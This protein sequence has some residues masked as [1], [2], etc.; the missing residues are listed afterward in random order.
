MHACQPSGPVASLFSFRKP[1]LRASG[2]AQLGSPGAGQSSRPPQLSPSFQDLFSY[3]PSLMLE[4]SLWIKVY[5]AINL[6]LPLYK[7]NIFQP[8]NYTE[9][10]LNC[11]LFIPACHNEHP[12]TSAVS[13][14][15]RA[16]DAA[17]SLPRS[18]SRSLSRRHCREGFSNKD[19]R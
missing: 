1:S 12:C 13:K 10:S 2:A 4:L 5:R 18:S 17:L 14:S 19:T 11:Q 6:Y 3:V 7:K 9:L 16:S 15:R 8:Q